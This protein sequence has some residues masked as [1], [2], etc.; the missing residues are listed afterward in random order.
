MPDQSSSRMSL[1]AA[2]LLLLIASVILAPLGMFAFEV[3]AQV[4]GGNNPPR[5]L[6]SPDPLSDSVS[7]TAAEFRV[8]EAG[9]ATYTVPLYTV[10][11]TAGVAPSVSLKY[12][13]Q[14][15]Y[16][17]LGKGWAVGGLSSIARCRATREA[18]DFLGAATPD[19]APRP[20]NLSA[21]DRYCLDGQRLVPSAATCPSA[22]GMSGVAL[23]TEI[24][25]FARVCAYSAGGS[26]TGPAFFTAE[27]KDGSISW[28][29]DRD[30]NGGANRPDG[31]FEATSSLSPGA[32]LV[33]AQTRFQDSTGN[34]ID[35]VYSENPAGPGTGEH[36]ISE[37]RYTGK[38]SLPGQSGATVAPYARLV[39]NYGVRPEQDWG[40][41]YAAG[42]VY[43]HSRRLE[44]ITSCGTMACGAIEQVRHYL[45]TYQQAYSGARQ[46]NLIGLQECRDSTATVCAAAT[47]FA[48]SSA[49]HELATQ[50]YAP[51]LPFDMTGF[52]GFK[53]G[54]I[55]GDGRTDMVYPRLGYTPQGESSNEFIV[56]LGAL[57]G[58]GRPT[59]LP[60][61][62]LHVA[63]LANRPE[64]SWHLFDYTG[65]GRDDL[66]VNTGTQGGGWHLYASNGS[67]FDGQSLIAHLGIPGMTGK[68][69]QAH[70][71]DLNGDGLTDIVYPRAGALRARIMERQGAIFAWGAERNVAINEASLGP[72]ASDCDDGFT[73][74]SRSIAG[75]PTPKTNFMQVADFNGDAASDLLIR[76]DT[77]VQRRIYGIP[78]CDIIPLSQSQ[79]GVTGSEWSVLPYVPEPD[80]MTGGAAVAAASADPCVE[81][82]STNTL[83]AFVVQELSTTAVG[84]SN[85]AGVAGGSPHSLAY[86]DV[87]GDGLSDLFVQGSDNAD[88]LPLVNT[89]TGFQFAPALSIQNYRNQTRFVDINGDGRAD[90][91]AVVNLGS[92]KAYYVRYA[93]A[94]GGFSPSLTPILGGNARICEGSSCDERTRMPIFADFDGDGHLDFLSLKM[95]GQPDVYVSRGSQRFVP[96]DVIVQVTNGMGAVTEISYAPMTNAA[97]YR[98]DVG[99]RNGLNWGRGSPVSD[100]LM[101]TYVVSAAAS[102]SVEGGS[103][104]ARTRMH[105]R[106]AGAKV[107]AGG[108]GFLGFREIV[109]I[110]PNQ[111]GGHV[112]TT[113]TYAQNFPFLGLPV[114]TTKRAV[115]GQA[116]LVP[117]CLNGVIS[118]ACFVT[119]GN[120]HPDL[121]G[122]WFSNSIQSWEMA[123]ANLASQ[124]AI[125]VRTMGTEESLRDPY[126]GEQT[127][128]VATAFA[129]G[130]HGNVTQT[131]V[132]TYTGASTLTATQITQNTYGDDTAK[133]R[134]GR[135]TASTITHR[136]PGQPDIVRTTGF[137]YAMSGAGTG[138]LTEERTQPGGAADQASA[139]S[140]LLD[141]FGNRVQ[142]TTC[143]AP[144][145]GCSVSGFQFHPTAL[146]A[147]KR[148]SRMEYDAQGRFPVATYEPFWSEGGGTE[149]QTSRILQRNVFGDATEVLDVNNVRSMS[150]AG[151]LGRPYFAW[152]QTTPHATPGN[153]GATSLTTYRWCSTGVGAV[154]CPTGARFREQVSATAMPRQ[155]TYFDALGRPVM[156]AVETFNANVGDQDVSAV[157]T[158]YDGVGRARRTSTPFFLP[159]TSGMEG[160]SDVAAACSSA[161]RAWTT[162]VYD[163]LGRPTLVQAA[164][165]SQV[166]STYAGLTTTTRDARNNPTTQTRNGKGEVIATQDAAGFLTQFGYNA[167]GNLTT[168]SRNAG[169]GTITNT[170]AYDVLG[171]K[172]LQVDP[173]TGTTA[174]QYNA[175]G[176]LIAQTD[177]GGYR[178]E[179]EIDARG[180]A[181]RVSAKLPG[182]AI[183]SQTTSTF[184]T[185]QYGVGQLTEESVIGQYA[186]WAGQAGT[187]LNY[188]RNMAYDAMG[189][190]M[191][192][193]TDV[194]GQWF[195]AAVAYDTLGRPWKAQDA[196]GAWVKTQYGSRGA[197]AICA[198]SPDD[199]NPSCP[200]GPDTYQRTLATDAWGNVV[201]E[202]RADSAAMEVRR[203]YHALTGRI[204]EIC[205]GNTACNLVKEAYVWDAAGNLASHQKEGRYLEGFTYDSLNR[206][207]EGR[208]TMANGVTVNQVM[209]ANAYDAL[210]N[211][212]SKNG[213]G[214]AYPGADGCV[215]AVPMA[216]SAGIPSLT[217]VAL[218]AYQQPPRTNLRTPRA[219][220]LNR[221]QMQAPER[222][223]RRYSDDDRPSWE[224]EADEWGLGLDE[225]RG[226][227]VWWRGTPR[228]AARKP[229]A[230][231]PIILPSA[232]R[233]LAAMTQPAVMMAAVSS[234]ASSPH[235]VNQT[236]DGTSAS[237]Y[238]YDDRGNQTLRDAPGTASDRTIRYSADGKAHEIQ[239]GNGQTT[240]F[241]YGPDGQRYKR[242]DGTTTTYYV[243]GVEV[244]VQ[245]GV[246]TARRYV[247][248]VALQTVVGGVVQ[249]TRFLFHDHLGSLIRIANADGTVAESLDY[250]AFGDRRAYGNPSGTGSASTLTPRGFTGHEYVD[251]TQVIHMN[252]RI[253]DQ[254][255]GRF[256]QPDPVIQEPTNAQ[257]WN[258]YTYVFNNPLAYTDPS[259]NI[260]ARQVLGIVIAVVGTIF[261]PQF[262]NVWAKIG[263]AMVIGFASG[264]VA[265]GT[266]QGGVFGAFTAALTFGIGNAAGMGPG[267]QLFAR[268]YTGGLIEVMQGGKF[269]HGF[270]SAG[271]TA[272]FMPQVGNIQNDVARTTVGALV[273]GTL[274][275]ATGSKFA[276]GAISGAIQ[277]AMAKAP[278]E[279]VRGRVP[280]YAQDVEVDPRVAA[281]AMAEGEEAMK[282]IRLRR[283]DDLD[284]LAVDVADAL[285]PIQNKWHT[286]VGVRIFN[287]G[288]FFEAGSVTSEGQICVRGNTCG[289]NLAKSINLNG[290][291]RNL[292]GS[293][294][295]HPWNDTFSKSDLAS[296][297]AARNWSGREHT[298]Y[299]TMPDRSVL[300]FDTGLV[301]K[302]PGVSDWPG[303]LN[304]T[305]RVR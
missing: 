77:Y 34:Y 147:V 142:S 149:V 252:G 186:A 198:S 47:S 86:G 126:T 274:S 258:A 218:P 219:S 172:T 173:D 254:Q 134:L 150:V 143:A 161:S 171:R 152:T 42:G 72:I 295:T 285:Q 230:A 2:A 303:Y 223:Y 78:G 79:T 125:H 276:N 213:V 169:A 49:R 234:V 229:A 27:R 15:G 82:I 238:Y 60:A 246:Q 195:T 64:G 204:A 289:V 189:R 59:F 35:Y 190:V 290:S 133:W 282:E 200:S 119:P 270:A 236:G 103:P 44:S 255:L 243:G 302:I 37:I 93:L 279:A 244:L 50:E 272:A 12:S 14:G 48:W 97:V 170:F 83:H 215:G 247:A 81:T 116:Y 231:G 120:P 8:D 135:L 66:F 110:D 94:S 257:S 194:D 16:G 271:L 40:R 226:D 99:A 242:Q 145:T 136:R 261:A 10:P 178:T 122:S 30:S 293:F 90:V 1:G 239:M 187:E 264:Y 196:S 23:A 144:A 209:L 205:G 268:A 291:N 288:G 165:G 260:T 253:Y 58:A 267:S 73:I 124:V 155:W 240:R 70:V 56:A 31:Y 296:A 114:Q 20:I 62:S 112:V 75:A 25:T 214:Y 106:Y 153:G 102:S 38:A 221:G 55:N 185:A 137:S 57:D 158:E 283:Y 248:G 180:R 104:T 275:A 188:R 115:L 167:A 224:N 300:S 235:A 41:S 294:H 179:R 211:V 305:K 251:G 61:G 111:H 277:G 241:W 206:V 151:G 67:A 85:Y 121:G 3:V 292:V 245:N 301:G 130:S 32:A 281:L 192:T 18:G 52:L 156:K 53:L 164:D 284:R 128:K 43:T 162:T 33:W 100:L 68:N 176:E 197:I 232:S 166:T 117:T 96:R 39:F 216:Q 265:S 26:S 259:G 154:P 138:L 184:D 13:S 9:A 280:R 160:P 24:D 5:V 174:F 210:G 212:C 225:P 63:P 6:V 84:V 199:T 141:D 163:I 175:L 177:N 227:A 46:E 273:G 203:Q 129:Y 51:E 22:G 139:T 286:E 208:L 148:Y 21:T 88:W 159:G 132:D 11:G 250:T 262:S 217:T 201:R 101:P 74:C 287:N 278:H 256:L 202:A 207:T 91:L 7:A 109:S 89:G 181:W 146:D 168:V 92:Y 298:T 266:L 69:D 65:D 17:P 29:G 108:R 222:S 157:C 228:P 182:G 263:Y 87:N 98:R 76:V 127:S 233:Q 249:A 113:T 299:V 28:Y 105:Y 118:N 36:L 269:G 131:V 80:P 54:D 191:N 19:G 95:S 140:Y 123:P 297:W 4:M 45:L 304:H 193:I 71:A 183:E 107:Q 220:A 237:F